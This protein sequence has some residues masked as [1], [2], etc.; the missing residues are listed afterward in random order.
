[1]IWRLLFLAIFLSSGSAFGQKLKLLGYQEFAQ[2][3][4]V[5]EVRFGGISGITWDESNQVMWAITDD[6]GKTG[7]PHVFKLHFQWKTEQFKIEKIEILP[8]K[9]DK[10]IKT[11]V[12]FDMEGVALLPWGNLLVTTEGDFNRRPRIPPQILE[13]KYDGSFIR[14]YPLPSEF[15]F[16]KSGKAKKGCSDN[17]CLESLTAA[18]ASKFWMVNEEPLIQDKVNEKEKVKSQGSFEFLRLLRYEMPEAWII[19]YKDE[20]RIKYPMVGEQEQTIHSSWG[21]SEILAKSEDEI[22]IVARSAS[23]DL[24]GL[25]FLVKLLKIQISAS[26][27][28]PMSAKEWV[29]FNL[30]ASQLKPPKSV[31]NI[32]AASWGPEYQGKRT[33]VLASDNNFSKNQKTQFWWIQFED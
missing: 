22:I 9:F 24:G 8:L 21:V 11:P 32:E 7:D 17:R 23:L 1:M 2:D 4:K 18:S 30:W 16:E 20:F 13:F 14:E 29:D 5:G 26:A 15:I 28:E 3:H 31:D 19:K 6:R 25:G 27:K 12:S 10:K 33:L